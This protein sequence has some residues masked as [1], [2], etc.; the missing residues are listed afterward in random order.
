MR[1]GYPALLTAVVL[2]LAALSFGP[3]R[4]AEEV[5]LPPGVEMPPQ[6]Q[7]WRAPP[8]DMTPPPAEA[9][10][11]AEWEP[12]DPLPLPLAGHAAVLHGDHIYVIGGVSGREHL[13]QRDVWM[14]KVSKKGAL[15]KWK[16]TSPLSAPLGFASAVLA[17]GRVYVAG[18]SGRMG[19]QHIYEKVYSA[20]VKKRGGLSA[21]REEEALPEKLVHHGLAACEGY[22]YV[23]GGFNGQEYRQVLNYAPIGEDGVLGEWRTADAL[24][25]HPIGRTYLTS[26]GPDLL[27][28]GGLWYDSQGEHVSSLVMRGRRAADGNVTAW[29]GKDTPKVAA[30]P[31]RYSLADHAGV[32]GE[33]FVYVLGGSGPDSPGVPTTQ[34]SWISPEKGWLTDWQFGPKLR[35]FNVLGGPQ[36]ARLFHTAA[37]LAGDFLYVL[38]GYLYVREPTAEV[39]VMRLREYAD[40]EWLKAKRARAD[41]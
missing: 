28:V 37:V 35:R 26:V 40:P 12:A 17:S 21:W 23:L 15:G 3:A 30:G 29:D 7:S 33:N 14:A 13:G 24:Y 20:E 34:A 4:A 36:D 19:M 2:V 22:L 27:A 32:T 39:L 5:K 31:L 41:R 25:P 8:V 1:S 16:K 18:G 10:W 38:G 9:R 6:P 11:G